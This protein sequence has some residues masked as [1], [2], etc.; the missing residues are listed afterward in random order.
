MKTLLKALAGALLVSCSSGTPYDHAVVA[1]VDVSATGL[2]AAVRG[3]LAVGDRVAV[4]LAPPGQGWVYR[5]EA[6]V[7]GEGPG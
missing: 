7:A 4:R 3:P 6:V 2:R 5:G 1:L